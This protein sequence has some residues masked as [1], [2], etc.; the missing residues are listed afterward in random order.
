MALV[1]FTNLD[2]DQIKITI[3]DYLRS[4]SN[5][6]D[7]D[8][9][10]SNLSAIINVLAYNTYI[11]SYN[12]NMVSNEVF[13]DGATLRENVVSLA[14]NIGYVPRSRRASKVEIS[15]LV[16]LTNFT[17]Y[18]PKTL[19]LQKGIAASPNISFQGNSFTFCAIDDATVS[20]NNNVAQFN[21]VPL[22]EG[23]LITDTFTVDYNIPNQKF[24]LGNVNID[25][26]TIKVTVQSE[27]G[28]QKFMMASDLFNVNE[29]SKVF[30]IQ[31]V[32]D[33]RYELFFG[34]GIFGK[35]LDNGSIISVSYIVTNGELGNNI[36]SFSYLGRII[37][38][39]DQPVTSGISILSPSSVSYGG[40]EIESVSSVKKYAPRIYASQ[41]RAVTAIDYETIISSYIYPE[42]ESISVFG[43]ED[44]NPPKY[45][46]V[47]ISIKPFFGPFIP[48]SIKDNIKRELRKYSVAGIV[49]EILDLKYLYVETD[50]GVYYN[51]NMAPSAS[52]VRT[53]VF[54][55][56][57]KYANSTELNK[58]G[59]RFKYS[60]YQKIIDDSHES[61]TS[62]ITKVQ[63]RRDLSVKLNEFA[64]Y[65]ICFGNAFHIK[66]STGYNIKSSGF[67]ITNIADTL[68]LSDIPNSDGKTGTI[69]FFKLLS[70]TEPVIMRK[71]VGTINYE[72]GE[73]RLIPIKFVSTTNSIQGQSIIEISAI[74][75]SNDVIGL[76]DL[77]LQ[78]DVNNSSITPYPDVISSGADISGS[79]YL[80]TSSY[81]NGTLTR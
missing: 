74:P 62:N 48:N 55:N 58:Y 65:E 18:F 32:E 19:T 47:F 23:Q 12:A 25:T 59:A 8:F 33:Q 53:T 67:K 24:I 14:R 30:F 49:H 15:F 5:F 13:I 10:G 69:F 31:E 66:N 28:I 42:T 2:F 73:I 76:Q 50:I 54:D 64:D 11:N 20:V 80:S 60:K 26:T 36:Y 41:N 17:D 1:N 22:Y 39:L 4:N 56:I 61:I 68:Y 29:N 40:A 16:D 72:K 51:S 78:L 79:S 37:D 57:Q 3:K 38:D 81:T 75:K 6:T 52:F 70:T 46:K 35:K 43:G 7:Y 9:E 27:I 71:S 34:D 21:N 44:L 77:Y 45:G 63:M